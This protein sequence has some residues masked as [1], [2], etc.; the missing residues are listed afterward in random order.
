MQNKRQIVSELD[1][2]LTLKTITETYQ[3]LS[4]IKMQKIR[5]SV[6]RTRDFLSQISA[7]YFEVRHSYKRKVEALAKKIKRK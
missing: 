3:E 6:L 4:A 1:F 2:T 5:N 7:V